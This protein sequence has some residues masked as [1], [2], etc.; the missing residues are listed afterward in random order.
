M[1]VYLRL[2]H[3][4]GTTSALYTLNSSTDY[5]IS[6][7]MPLVFPI[8]VNF[9]KCY[10]TKHYHHSIIFLQLMSYYK[11]FL[12]LENLK[13]LTG[14]NYRLDLHM[15][16]KHT[17]FSLAIIIETHKC[18]RYSTVWSRFAHLIRGA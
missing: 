12:L 1:P 9:C 7:Y 11:M 5:G 17:C 15:T 8:A 6:L 4:F 3:L 14:A 18:M 10:N 13:D 2:Q 16:L